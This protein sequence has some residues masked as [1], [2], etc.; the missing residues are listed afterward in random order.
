MHYQVKN[1]FFSSFSKAI[2]EAKLDGSEVIECA[3][4]LRRWAP[5]P[6]VTAKRHRVY[7]ERL[8]ARQAYEK[9]IGK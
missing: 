2:A 8:A 4:G 1:K 9:M 3:T 6:P 5:A 7:Q